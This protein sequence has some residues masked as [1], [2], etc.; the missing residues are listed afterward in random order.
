MD[1]KQSQITRQELVITREEK[2]KCKV[3]FSEHILFAGENGKKPAYDV[4]YGSEKLS[5]NL[6]DWS[7]MHNE[8]S[9]PKNGKGYV[10]TAENSKRQYMLKVEAVLYEEYASC[11]W[12]VYIKNIGKSDSSK[13]SHFSSL[14]ESFFTPDAELYYS[15]G[16]EDTS[17]DFKPHRLLLGN[18]TDKGK[19]FNGVDGRSSEKYLPFFNL[20]TDD[21]GYVFSVGWS[22]QWFSR[23]AEK[24]DNICTVDIRQQFLNAALLPDEE[25]RTPSVGIC[26]Y[27]GAGIKGF[28]LFRQWISD[29]IIPDEIRQFVFVEPD[30]CDNPVAGASFPDDI[31][32]N[33]EILK[34]NNITDY[35]YIWI[36]AIWFP[37]EK[38]WSKGT[39]NWKADKKFYPNGLR[40]ISDYLKSEGKKLLLW[41]DPEVV[42]EGTDLWKIGKKNKNLMIDIGKPRSVW[43]YADDEAFEVICSVIDASVKENGVSAFRQDFTIAPLEYWRAADAELYSGR[44]GICENHYIS[45]MYRFLDFLRKNN[46]SLIIDN[47]A[48]GGKRLDLEM[49]RRSVPLWRSDYNC[50]IRKDLNEATQCQTYG[51]SLWLPLS[52]SINGGAKTRYDFRSQLTSILHIGAL[53]KEEN[54][55]CFKLMRDYEKLKSFMTGYFFPLTSFSA[56]EK[57]ILAFQYELRE[58]CSGF[59]IVFLRKNVM[60]SVVT[61]CFNGLE[62]DE[63]YS[64][65]DFDNP[66]VSNIYS[67]EALMKIGININ[68]SEAPKA[69]IMRFNRL[70]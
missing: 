2:D 24:N 25:I 55:E 67:G 30:S 58:E 4:C 41:Y 14:K 70:Q 27:T 12:T 52:A 1:F 37:R 18:F 64:V 65:S 57:D 54:P 40:S 47:C 21:S 48:S 59:V 60:P 63:F 31:K 68:S 35:D 29:C 20:H 23:F 17:D 51:L 49:C 11:E 45:N 5:E 15:T 43:N 33:V 38:D 8:C 66:E 62:P 42:Y 44:T 46:P 69:V 19:Y 3:W 32:A 56:S 28:N 34:K 26:F 13:I 6:N 50:C 7:F 10:I 36:D 16:C 22:G 61:V 9:S 53:V 39:G